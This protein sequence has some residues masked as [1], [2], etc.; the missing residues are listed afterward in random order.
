MRSA[1][2]FLP[3]R[4]SA[5]PQPL[6]EAWFP[7]RA[8]RCGFPAGAA[9][10]RAGRHVSFLHPRSEG[11]SWAQFAFTPASSWSFQIRDSWRSSHH[12][13]FFF[14]LVK[15]PRKAALPR[16]ADICGRVTAADKTGPGSNFDAA[17]LNSRRRRLLNTPSGIRRKMFQVRTDRH[18]V[19]RLAFALLACGFRA[20]S[21]WTYQE[22]LDQRS[23]PFL[24]C[25]CYAS[26]DAGPPQSAYSR[27]PGARS[28]VCRAK[29]RAEAMLTFRVALPA[30]A[31]RVRVLRYILLSFG[32]VA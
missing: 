27:H 23:F 7:I 18:P 4:K 9:G 16:G 24:R 29:S 28:S 32:K 20:D 2:R 22:N 25:T 13:A 5:C 17:R 12:A 3:G 14:L 26:G 10:L 8:T 11:F 15:Q 6:R 30:T 21:S 19:F 1:Y 31:A